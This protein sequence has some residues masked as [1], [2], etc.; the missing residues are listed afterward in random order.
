MPPLPCGWISDTDFQFE[1]ENA[2]QNQLG[3][4]ALDIVLSTSDHDE[5]NAKV[6]ADW[7]ED[8]ANRRRS[9]FCAP[10]FEDGYVEVADMW[11]FIEDWRDSFMSNLRR[12]YASLASRPRQLVHP[13]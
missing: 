1:V 5:G 13:S 2:V 7:A 4:R 3:D 12:S 10:S 9:D 8:Q 11:R 6:L